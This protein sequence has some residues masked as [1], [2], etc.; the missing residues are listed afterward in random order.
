MG[1][2]NKNSGLSGNEKDLMDKIAEVLFGGTNQ[3]RE[4]ISELDNILEHKY[5]T[6]YVANV[7]TWMTSRYV[8]SDDKSTDALVKEGQMRR[9]DNKLSY[10][11]ALKVY[12]FVA[13]KQASVLPPHLLNAVLNSYGLN[14]NTGS[15]EDVIP[16]AFGEYGYCATNPIPTKGIPANEIYLKRL[17]LLSGE[18]FHWERIGS[19]RAN[20]IK[21]PIDMYK[22]ISTTGEALCTIYISPYQNVISSKAPKG[23]YIE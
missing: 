6:K 3:M 1:L 4:Q 21:N 20:N 12:N 13:K 9:P 16:G 14:N 10:N 5:E 17:S 19:T 18:K 2:F 8:R 22:I 7:L 15:T 11:D 23:F